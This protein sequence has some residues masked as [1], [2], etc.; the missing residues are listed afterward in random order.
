VKKRPRYKIKG[1]ILSLAEGLALTLL[2]TLS[3]SWGFYGHRSINRLAVYT[4]PTELMGFYKANADYLSEH[5]VDP[6]KRRY[7]VEEEAP[8]HYL[9]ADYYEQAVP[10]DTIPHYWKDAVEKFSEDTLK[11]YGIGPWHLERM[12][13]RLQ[14]AFGKKDKEYILKQSAEIGHY[15]ADLCVPLHSTMNY[16]GQLTN[17]KGIHGFWESRLPELYA[18]N[19]DFYVGKA[20]YVEHINS[21]IWEVFEESFAARDSVLRFEKELSIDFPEEKKYAFEE[22]GNGLVKVYSQ[23]YSKA[24]DEKLAGMVERRMRRATYLV[25]CLWYT[26]WINAGSPDLDMEMAP[27]LAD[28]TLKQHIRADQHL[29]REK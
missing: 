3:I 27:V 26:A 1:V 21:L 8:R 19:Y 10:L 17:Q 2:L 24:Y 5:S 20:V 15:A 28:T 23:E 4:L 22:K 25:G 7:S 16:N 6:D 13:W 11:A 18:G 12:I 29:E 9:D 14:N